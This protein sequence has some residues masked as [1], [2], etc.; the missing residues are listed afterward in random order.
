MQYDIKEYQRLPYSTGGGMVYAVAYP[1][2]EAA[3]LMK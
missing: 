2:K 1:L 3:C